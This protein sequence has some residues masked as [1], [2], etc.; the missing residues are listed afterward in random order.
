MS[1]I[2]LQPFASMTADRKGPPDIYGWAF[3]INRQQLTNK[4]RLREERAAIYPY[5]LESCLFY[6]G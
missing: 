4:D 3:F 6:Q 1:K 2:A 5:S